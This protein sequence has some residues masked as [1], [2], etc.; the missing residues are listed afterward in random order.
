MLIL[1]YIFSSIPGTYK[2]ARLLN[3]TWARAANGAYQLCK[4]V[5][6]WCHRRAVV[7]RDSNSLSL[8]ASQN[9]GRTLVC[10]PSKLWPKI[11]GKVVSQVPWMRITRALLLGRGRAFFNSYPMNLKR[12]VLV[13][14]HSKF[15]RQ[16]Y[17]K[18]LKKRS[19]IN[20]LHCLRR[21]P[22]ADPCSDSWLPFFLVVSMPH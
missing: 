22:Y 2:G 19:A 3:W 15:L 21:A 1:I 17:Q 6:S 4:H 11:Y 9:K 14:C 5:C 12:S 10:Q 7:L 16:L 18:G 20:H 8:L 13:S